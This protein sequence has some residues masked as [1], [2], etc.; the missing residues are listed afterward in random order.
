MTEDMGVCPECGKPTK[1]MTSRGGKVFYGCSNYP[2]C[3]FMSWDLPTGKK[4]PVCDGYLVEVE[5]KII[6][7][8]KKC[9]YT[10]NAK[11]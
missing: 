2:G 9:N 10:E 3:K 8:N 6:C 7:S 1:K 5:G 11:S 4:C